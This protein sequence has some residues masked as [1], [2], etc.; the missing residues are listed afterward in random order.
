MFPSFWVI[1]FHSMFSIVSNHDLVLC[2]GECS[3]VSPSQER[4]TE[5]DGPTGPS[6]RVWAFFRC[7]LIECIC[8][9]HL[10]QKARKW[11][12][13]KQ[14]KFISY[15]WPFA[16]YTVLFQRFFMPISDRASIVPRDDLLWFLQFP[17]FSSVGNALQPTQSTA[18]PAIPCQHG[19]KRQPTGLTCRLDVSV[20][21]WSM[22]PFGPFGTAEGERFR[23]L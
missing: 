10:K 23:T 2:C 17:T 7:F 22:E 8:F 13:N 15:S 14:V 19:A 21:W 5:I 6:W 18:I 12:E 11:M 16:F 1:S 4:S 9:L 3:L 20:S